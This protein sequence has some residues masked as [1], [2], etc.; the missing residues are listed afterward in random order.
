MTFA[1]WL[2][3]GER[4][5]YTML[6]TDQ[7]FLKEKDLEVTNYLYTSWESFF[8]QNLMR[9]RRETNDPEKYLCSFLWS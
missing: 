6:V 7:R 8:Q 4:I 9:N 3:L 1:Y 5:M 2:E